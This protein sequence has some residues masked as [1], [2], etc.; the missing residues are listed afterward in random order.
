MSR[1]SPS[2]VR[3]A[4]I[5]GGCAGAA[6]LA[7]LAMRSNPPPL[8][9]APSPAAVPVGAAPE[10]T[11]EPAT[12]RP[13]TEPP[14][15]ETAA[16]PAPSADVV[17]VAPD[18]GALVAGRAAPGATVTIYADDQPI[19]EAKADA[20][21]NFVAMFHA[22]PAAGPQTLTLGG[23]V[24]GGAETR[25]DQVVVLLPN[26]PTAPPAATPPAAPPLTAT[27]AA[28][29]PAEPAPQIAATAILSPQSAELTPMV[30][31][32]GVAADR[33][34]LA[35]ISYAD[36]GAVN[37]AGFGLAGAELR[38][39]VNDALAR[40]GKVDPEGR[41]KL[42]LGDVAVGVYRL[43]VDQIDS[44]GRVSSRIE[45]PFQRDVPQPR[46]DGAS[47]GASGEM[48]VVVQPGN[49]LWTLARIHYGRGVLYTRIFNENSNLIRDPDRIFPGQIF[50]MPGEDAAPEP[51]PAPS[52][53][54]ALQKP[55]AE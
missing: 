20:K 4:I 18:G 11:P 47:G 10:L 35:S 12:P 7:Y 28:T 5:L 31:P 23:Q 30:R 22:E 2:Q 42:A 44:A 52:E 53:Q 17:R 26:I 27:P 16:A 48:S 33:V 32:S 15:T 51:Q 37:L 39:Y 41:W 14:A 1:I 19:A 9:P 50:R 29:P 8:V 46:P 13:A 25:S 21:G 54:P 43:R 40:E 38:A 24:P 36:A 45:T 3:T 49:N 34:S 6:A 55:P